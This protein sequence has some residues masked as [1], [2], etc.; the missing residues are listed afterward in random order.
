MFQSIEGNKFVKPL[1]ARFCIQ[2][3]A[4]YCSAIYGREFGQNQ[5]DFLLTCY[6]ATI[7]A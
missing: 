6:E 3:N 5:S 4:Q 1:I 7:T 2:Q